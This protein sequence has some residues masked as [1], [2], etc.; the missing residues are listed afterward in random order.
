MNPTRPSSSVS[1]DMARPLTGGTTSGSAQEV[2]GD[3]AS[4]VLQV[5]VPLT[6]RSHL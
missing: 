1:P 4:D 3:T 2:N 5:S 6:W